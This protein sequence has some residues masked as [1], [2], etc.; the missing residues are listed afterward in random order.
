MERK[1]LRKE[2]WRQSLDDVKKS[3]QKVKAQER[4]TAAEGAHSGRKWEE[5]VAKRKNTEKQEQQIGRE[6][7]VYMLNHWRDD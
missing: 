4:K 5:V 1:E 6:G 2:E 7:Q 3:K